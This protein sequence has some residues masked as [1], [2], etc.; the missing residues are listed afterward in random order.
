M[1]KMSPEEEERRKKAILDGMSPRRREHILKK[2]YDKWDPFIKPNDPIDIRK[3]VTNRTTQMLIREFMQAW[4]PEDWSNEFGGG[5]FE[6][7]Y[8][9][10]NRNEKVRGMFEFACW[11][12]ELLKK[13]GHI[14]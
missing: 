6:L 1:T 11:Y 9:I 8:G 10:I 3:D 14:E 13:E 4:N 12:K 5:A 2:G 7:C